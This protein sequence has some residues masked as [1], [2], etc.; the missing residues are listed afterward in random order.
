MA[1][2]DR[3]VDLKVAFECDIAVRS[4]DRGRGILIDT[5][6]EPVTYLSDTGTGKA[7]GAVVEYL[8]MVYRWGR[9]VEIL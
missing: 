8:F 7:K 2:H 4:G 5:E 3:H 9:V 6:S 1:F